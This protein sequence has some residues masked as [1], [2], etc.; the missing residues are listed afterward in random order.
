MM[1]RPHKINDTAYALM[2]DDLQ[3]RLPTSIAIGLQKAGAFSGLHLLPPEEG[4]L[5][6]ELV[7]L[8]RAIDGVDGVRPGLA[9]VLR[10][11]AYD[12][13][14]VFRSYEPWVDRRTVRRPSPAGLVR[15]LVRGHN[16]DDAGE[17]IQVVDR[18]TEQTVDVY[19]NRLVKLFA[20]Q[21]RSRLHAVLAEAR[22]RSDPGFLHEAM[23][24]RG[25]LDRACQL[26]SFLDQVSMPAFLPLRLSMVL[27]NRD[28]YPAALEGFLEFSRGLAV[29]LDG[30]AKY[31]LDSEVSDAS[32]AG[33][34]PKKD[35]IDKMHAYRD[36]IRDA[37]G[38]R[39]VALA[40]ILYPG[41]TIRYGDGIAALKAVPGEAD[42]LSRCV[43]DILAAVIDGAA[44]RAPNKS[45]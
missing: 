3:R 4:T 31:K 22:R 5:A 27:M 38:K 2:I 37:S 36:A 17:L 33:A 24:L 41:P 19:E 44:P 10:E 8:R 15:A 40:S 20:Q 13:Y 45:V 32:D 26:A 12:H 42:E 18:R 6:Q 29:R 9:A 43:G 14:A 11:L 23:S 1:I 30:E 39:V 28:P 25:R 16:L 7:R 34:H 35:D 21:T